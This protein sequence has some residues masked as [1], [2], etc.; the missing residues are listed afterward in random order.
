MNL[1][2]FLKTIYNVKITKN[3]EKYFILNSNKNNIIIGFSN[4]WNPVRLYIK[5]ME[6][7]TKERKIKNFNYRTDESVFKT[8]L[9]N[10]K[11]TFIS[12]S[13]EFIENILIINRTWNSDYIKEKITIELNI[14]EI[15]YLNMKIIFYD[16]DRNNVKKFNVE[17]YMKNPEDIL[18]IKNKIWY[19]LYK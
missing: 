16:I 10:D 12:D 18:E 17:D 6:I 5:Y 14:N 15:K 11:N 7:E 8:I 2:D 13:I 9:E 1:T 3:K 4:N 19:K